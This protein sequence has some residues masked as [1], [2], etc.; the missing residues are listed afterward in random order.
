MNNEVKILIVD[1]EVLIAEYLKD[2][3]ASLDFH[4]VRLAHNKQQAIQ[5]LDGFQ[6]T[7]VL[8]DIRMKTELE[9]IELAGLINHKYN[10]PFIF[11]T[12]HSDKEIVEKAL[13]TNPTAYITKPFNKMDVY[14]AIKIVMKEEKKS[15]HDFILVKDGYDS[16]KIVFDTILYVESSGNY[17]NI[18]TLQKKF[19]LRYSMDWFLKS[20]SS[21]IF[22]K[23]HRSYIVNSTK[24]QRYTSRSVFVNGI[25]IPI[26]RKHK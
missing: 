26:S 23:V 19:T 6:P 21:A 17:I 13:D 25:E 3:L 5:E 16:V 11:I 15:T 8:L 2:V 10:L 1:D 24:I 18:Y 7:F 20:V 4:H 22:Q 9:G 12:A 14:A